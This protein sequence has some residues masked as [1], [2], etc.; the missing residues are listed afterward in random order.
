S[1]AIDAGFDTTGYYCPFDMD[2]NHRVWDGD[3]NGT[4]II[5]IG[6]YE[7]NS[8]AFGGIEGY[9]YKPTTG[10][11][12]DYV[13]LKINNQPG[14]FTFSDSVGNF[15]CKLP[16]GVYDVYAERV[17]YEDV[18]QYGIEVFDGQFTQVEIPMAETVDVENI[19]YSIVN[20][21]LRNYPNPFNPSTTISSSIPNDSY[22]ELS[23]F[24]IKGQKVK[25]LVSDHISAG[26]HSVIWN[27]K[28]SNNKSVASGIYFYK[29]ST[30]K[31]SA[32]KKMLLLK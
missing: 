6:P 28:D 7:Y 31:S 23:I 27:G 30:G 10:E 12:V 32:M 8:P 16:A 1:L 19:Q 3:N 24:N 11:H 9:T 18:I 5:D 4:D 15:Q 25:Q 17:F 22:I 13:L 21:Q 20:F 14:E 2:Y 26:E 29:L